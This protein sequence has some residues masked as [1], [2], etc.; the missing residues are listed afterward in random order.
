MP[1][2]PTINQPE[3]NPLTV[4]SS[5]TPPPE[6]KMVVIGNSNFATNGWFSQQLNSDL[7]FN[8]LGWLASDEETTLS[9]SPKI[10]TNRRLNLG[11]FQAGLI[12]WLALFIIPFLGL[13]VAIVTWWKRSR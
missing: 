12:S 7:L 9:I 3:A 5:S 1:Q 6:T 11:E 4:P 10:P 8:S 13:T 2:P